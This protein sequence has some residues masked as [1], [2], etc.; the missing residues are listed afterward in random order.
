[1]LYQHYSDLAD[2]RNLSR[3]IGKIQP[4]EVYNLA[5]QSH[6]RVSFDAPEYTTD[7]TDTGTVRLLEAIREVGIQPRF[8]QASSL[9]MFGLVQEVPQKETPPFYRK[10]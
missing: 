4:A 1:M 8:N 6:V 9:E 5:A 3:L 2:G 10:W 7:I